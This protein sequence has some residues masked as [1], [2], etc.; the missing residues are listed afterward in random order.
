M[1]YQFR[2][3]YWRARPSAAPI[4]KQLVTVE[5]D[6]HAEACRLVESWAF[7][8]RWHPEAFTWSDDP[9]HPGH[10]QERGEQHSRAG[11]LLN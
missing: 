9:G 1:R 7:G 3:R 5:A 8:T 10:E 6:S 2:Y 4:R 11:V